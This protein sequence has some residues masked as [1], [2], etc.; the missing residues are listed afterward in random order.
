MLGCG[1]AAGHSDASIDAALVLCTLHN[2]SVLASAQQATEGRRRTLSGAQVCSNSFP[3][4]MLAPR[5]FDLNTVLQTISRHRSELCC[6]ALIACL[7]AAQ[8]APEIGAAAGN[9]A[10][11]SSDT[12]SVE[13]LK[14]L[15]VHLASPASQQL[16]TTAAAGGKVAVDA[17]TTPAAAVGRPKSGGL[18]RS[19]TM[20]SGKHQQAAIGS[21]TT[22]AAAAG[23]ANVKQMLHSPSTAA[24][25]KPGVFV[26]D[27]SEN[28]PAIDFF[29]KLVAERPPLKNGPTDIQANGKTA[30]TSPSSATAGSSSAPRFA[31]STTTPLPSSSAAD[32]AA[33]AVPANTEL[34]DQLVANEENYVANILLRCLKLC[35]SAFDGPPTKADIVRWVNRGT[36]ALWTQVGITLEHVVIWWSH[37]PLACRPVS[38]TRHLRDWLLQLQPADAPEP[39]LSTLR[40]LGETLTVY[41]TGSTW[42]AQFRL[43][44]V[45]GALPVHHATGPASSSSSASFSVGYS[46]GAIGSLI[47]F[48]GAQTEVSSE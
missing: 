48:G 3:G 22:A 19:N 10:D 1:A 40:G 12:S 11:D 27:A 8:C 38:S 24:F 6:L 33:G 18:T 36:R 17:T 5:K 30:T 45:A 4:L 32:A 29:D 23:P 14:A 41:V 43:A 15:T 25:N 47:G 26:N 20:M 21:S 31:A 13:I 2:G 37:A 16:T 28:D 42:D 9:S 34:L 46:S 35:P 44:L 39:V 7:V